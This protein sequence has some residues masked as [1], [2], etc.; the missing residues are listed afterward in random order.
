M[1]AYQVEEW[2]GDELVSSHATDADDPV[3]AVEKVTGQRV[4][5]RSLQKRWFRVVDEDARSAQEFSLA[6]D[7]NNA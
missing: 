3:S 2:H 1:P 6:D 4:S 5:P 7:E